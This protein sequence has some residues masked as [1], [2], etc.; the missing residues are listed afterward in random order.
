[1]ERS[2]IVRRAEEYA[3]LHIHQPGPS[4][5]S[6]IQWNALT[7]FESLGDV[8]MTD[9]EMESIFWLCSCEWGTVYN[10]VA[11]ITRARERNPKRRG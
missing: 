11:V 1:M 4:L 7:I 3:R 9:R 10:L 8:D 2:E 5:I 6:S